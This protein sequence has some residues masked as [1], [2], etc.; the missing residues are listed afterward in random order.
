MCG[1][2]SCCGSCSR[3]SQPTHEGEFNLSQQLVL[4]VLAVDAA[5][6]DCLPASGDA[7]VE[8]TLVNLLLAE[9]S[10]EQGCDSLAEA[11]VRLSVM[12]HQLDVVRSHFRLAAK[13]A[14]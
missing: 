4:N 3:A 9:L 11:N 8:P 13:M 12:A 7:L 10:E 2:A 6:Q 1:S 14:G 5:A